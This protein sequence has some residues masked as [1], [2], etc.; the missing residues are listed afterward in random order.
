M[1]SVLRARLQ[2]GGNELRHNICGFFGGIVNMSPSLVYLGERNSRY[3]K[4]ITLHGRTHCARVN[5]VIAHIGA[6][7]DARD[8]QV[9]L[10]LKQTCK[11]N[12]HA[13]C[14]CAV[15]ILKPIGALVHVQRR[16]ECE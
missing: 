6:I 11:C 3:A 12:M 1:H 5:G 8:H 16:M 13:I 15:D 14:R 10:G 9:R 4:Q 2:L 7:V